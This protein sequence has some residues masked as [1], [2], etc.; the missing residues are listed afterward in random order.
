LAKPQEP[1]RPFIPQLASPN[2]AQA[3]TKECQPGTGSPAPFTVEQFLTT[4]HLR[5]FPITH[6]EPGA[7]FAIR[8]V[9]SRFVLGNNTFQIQLAHSLKYM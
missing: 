1:R 4:G 2:S 9:W 7:V 6:L 5:V 8:D 3:N